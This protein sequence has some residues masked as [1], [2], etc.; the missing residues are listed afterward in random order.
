MILC[1]LMFE[2]LSL[3]PETDI[4]ISTPISILETKSGAVGWCHGAG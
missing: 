1:G 4:K 3:F 2:L